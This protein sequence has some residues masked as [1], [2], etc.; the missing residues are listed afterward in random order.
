VVPQVTLLY[1]GLLGLLVAALGINVTLVR[2]KVGVYV[3]PAAPPKK[4]FVAIRA[5]GNAIEWTPM[6]VIMM[7][8]VEVSGGSSLWLHIVGGLVVLARVLHG[9]GF[10]TRLR[11]SVA[12]AGLTWLV[13]VWLPWWALWLHFAPVK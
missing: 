10:S 6:L 8:L 9:V 4:L 5:H 1:G 12:G 11:T 3:D 13:A 2:W 7:L